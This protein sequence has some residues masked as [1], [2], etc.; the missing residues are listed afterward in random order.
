[1]EFI[2]RFCNVCRQPKNEFVNGME[3]LRRCRCDWEIGFQE[4][5]EK[6]V[7]R[8]F[9]KKI[10]GKPLTLT[11][12]DPPLFKNGGNG[13]FTNFINV[14]KAAVAFRL[15]RYCFEVLNFCEDTKAREYALEKSVGLRRNLFIRGPAGSGR[16][17]L[18]AIMK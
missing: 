2:E 10:L 13:K 6:T 9:R 5:Y 12:W 3:I 16:G 8:E 7:T 11:D 1:M 18:V 17:L 4:R 15:H 14:M